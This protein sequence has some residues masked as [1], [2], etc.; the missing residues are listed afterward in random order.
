MDFPFYDINISYEENWRKGPPVASKNVDI[1]KRSAKKRKKFLGFD[2]NSL[3]GIPAGPLLN[4]DFMKAAFDWGFDVSTYKTVRSAFFPCHPHPN[5]LFVDSPEDLHPEKTPRLTAVKKHKKHHSEVSITNS[6][7]VPS[8]DPEIWQKDVRKALAHAKD[9][10]LLILSFMGTVRKDQTQKEFINDFAKAARRAL[11][12]GAKVLEVNLS[13]P[14]L[15][16]EG[17]VCYDLEMTKKICQAIRKVIGSTPLLIK[18]GYYKNEK[19]LLRLAQITNEYANGVAAINTLQVEI[20]DKKGR[21]ALPGKMR[22]RSGVC[23][24]SIRWAGL[25]TVK[26]LNN[27]RLKNNFDFVIVGVG[28][29]MTAGDYLEYRKSGADLVQSATGAMFN[30]YLAHEIFQSEKCDYLF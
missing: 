9:G 25:E 6:F 10:Q 2:V 14:N 5:V 15:G 17:L 20:V 4:S 23:G 18:I 28:G 22:L 8:Q 21:Q 30:H 27:I 13:C 26:K 16:N 19:D 11:E 7:G 12:T 3:F 29:V 24:K 1:P